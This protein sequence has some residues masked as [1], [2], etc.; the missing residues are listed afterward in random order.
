[1]TLR[2]Y[3]QRKGLVIP[4]ISVDV[5]HGK[6]PV[7]HC[8]DCGKVAEGRVGK[9]DRFECEISVDGDLAPEVADKLVEIAGKCPVHRTLEATSAVMTRLKADQPAG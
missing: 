6:V 9:I 1:M 8:E 3:V 7:E 4:R 2:M 5:R